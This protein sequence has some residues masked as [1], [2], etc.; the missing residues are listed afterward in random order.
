MPEHGDYEQP[1]MPE[2]PQDVIGFDK[3]LGR[4]GKS[5]PDDPS[6]YLKEDIDQ[7]GDVLILDPEK[8]GKRLPNIQFEKML[9]RPEP[10]GPSETEDE[11]ILDVNIDA[12]RPRIPGAPDF[13]KYTGREEKKTLDD[14][15]VFIVNLDNDPIPNDP[16]LPKVVAHN[17]G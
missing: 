5:D 11:L 7:E 1:F 16:S 12:I 13:D 6:E 4:N 14:D 8:L 17:F 10:K 3:M 2:K 9:G 15:D